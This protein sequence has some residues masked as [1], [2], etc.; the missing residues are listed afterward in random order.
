MGM[1]TGRDYYTCIKPATKR[2]FGR[3]NDDER[4]F[5]I[6]QAIRKG[7]RQIREA[8]R[9]GG[10]TADVAHD[11]RLSLADEVD[12]LVGKLVAQGKGGYWDEI[13][14]DGEE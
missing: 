9:H 4:E 6:C 3:I 7:G 5:I 13:S 8:E 12:S 1:R 10:I 11:A 14:R 2:R